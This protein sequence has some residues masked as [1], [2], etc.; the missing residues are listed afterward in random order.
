MYDIGRA[1]A[2]ERY[3]WMDVRKMPV[4]TTKFLNVYSLIYMGLVHWFFIK[5]LNIDST[6][7]VITDYNISVLSVLTKFNL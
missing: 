5:Y 4:F 1:L 7:E 2:S 3:S 6:Y